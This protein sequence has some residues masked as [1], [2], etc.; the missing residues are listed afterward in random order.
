MDMEMVAMLII[1]NAGEAR[2]LAY[3]ALSEA[4]K[5]DFEKAEELMKQAEESFVKAHHAQTEI[6]VSEANGTK[7]EVSVLLIHSQDHLMTSMLALELVKELIILHKEKS[8][9]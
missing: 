9:R 2:S 7:T 6:L 8:D 4:K 3:Q 5:G 1:A